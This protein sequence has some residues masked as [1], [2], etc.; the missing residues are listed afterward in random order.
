MIGQPTDEMKIE[1]AS[2]VGFLHLYAGWLRTI[3]TIF[4]R[5][6]IIWAKKKTQG[7]NLGTPIWYY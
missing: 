7:G 2:E 4:L 6:T 3:D 1:V 5:M